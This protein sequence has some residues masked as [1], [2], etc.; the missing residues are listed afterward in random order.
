MTY[1][2]DYRG[3]ERWPMYPPKIANECSAADGSRSLRDS[4]RAAVTVRSTDF[5]LLEEY[6]ALRLR[7]GNTRWLL[8]GYEILPLWEGVFGPNRHAKEPQTMQTIGKVVAP[9]KSMPEPIEATAEPTLKPARA[10]AEPCQAAG[11][12]AGSARLNDGSARSA[13]GV[14]PSRGNTSYSLHP[15]FVHLPSIHKSS[16][17]HEHNQGDSQ[18]LGRIN[19]GER[20]SYSRAAASEAAGSSGGIQIMWLQ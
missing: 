14:E 8:G 16:P 5:K 20:P 15:P 10:E 6:I 4:L 7:K 3:Q 19:I 1:Y 12:S 13:Y 18:G 2:W 11:Q 9:L 17:L